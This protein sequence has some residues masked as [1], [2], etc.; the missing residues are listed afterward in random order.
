MRRRKRLIIAAAVLLPLVLFGAY[1]ALWLYAA[2]RVREGLPQW[3]AAMRTQHLDLSWQG[4][5]VA[6]YPLAF[7]LEFTKIAVRD[8]DPRFA[9]DVLAPM[10][11]AG[12][13]P[14]HPFVWH[15]DLPAGLTATPAGGVPGSA[16]VSAPAATGTV[17]I[18][19]ADARLWLA[20]HEPH[21][22]A[23][24]VPLAARLVYVWLILPARPPSGPDEPALGVAL[25]VHDL[26]LPQVPPPFHN[27]VEEASLGVTVMGP[28]PPGPPRQAAA[29]WR[30]A[31]GT[32]EVDHVALR[33]GD[34]G[35]AASG[36]LALD[37][38]LQPIGAFSGGVGGYGEFMKA[39]AASGRIGKRKA[40]LATTALS[41]FAKTGPDGRK[42]IATSFSIQDGEMF[43]GP[44]KIGPMPHIDWD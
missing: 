23:G 3:A 33:W 32:L 20:V 42:R 30:D 7:R 43:L 25:D 40:D 44:I 8:R 39:L 37:A 10:L 4:V 35:L 5:R 36:T 12:A 28:I 27:P 31:G 29:A 22:A 17:A 14:W 13:R 9:A 21:V 34:L 24:A 41:F 19:D 16:V 38:D 15:L 26:I 6:G 18:V 2:H 11:T 1:T